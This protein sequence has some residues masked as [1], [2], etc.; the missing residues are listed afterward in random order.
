[1]IFGLNYIPGTNP[2]FKPVDGKITSMK[3]LFSN[4]AAVYYKPH[5]FSSGVGTMR[6]VSR[7]LART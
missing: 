1:M 7:K 4:N 6:N 5:S 2:G 3:S